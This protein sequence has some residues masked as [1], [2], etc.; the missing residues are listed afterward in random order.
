MT[1]SGLSARLAH[2][3]PEPCVEVNPDDAKA[4]GLQHDGFARLRSPHGEC[5]LKVAVSAGQQRGSLFA[6]IHWSAETASTRARGR[7]GDAGERSLFRT[8]GSEGNAGC[9]R[10]CHVCLSRFCADARAVRAAAGELV[11]ARAGG[12]RMRSVAREQ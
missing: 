7:I 1:R 6:P 10:A 12:E 2:H 8:A 5:V 3:A 4:Y 11:G 9:G